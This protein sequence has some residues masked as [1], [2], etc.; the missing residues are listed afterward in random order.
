[1][2][3]RTIKLRNGG[4]LE[5][6][7]TPEF[8]NIVRKSMK[9]SEFREITDDELRSFVYSSFKGAIDKAERELEE[10]ND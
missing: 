2:E 9:I 1:M 5:I 4:N 6:D 8:Y 3:K 10:K 7:C